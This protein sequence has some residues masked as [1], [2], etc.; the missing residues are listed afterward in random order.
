MALFYSKSVA[1]TVELGKKLGSKLKRGNVVAYFGPMG[2][3][4]TAFTHGLAAGLGIDEKC[5]SSPTFAL[6]HEYRGE[7]AVLY[8]FDMYRISTWDDLYSTGYFDYL[9]S[10]E[11]LAVE[12]S[13]NIENALPDDCIRVNFSSGSNENE[14]NIEIIGVDLD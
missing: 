4:K 6:V 8:H 7:N 2:M 1:D 11:I 12:W 3:G 10:S 13:E 9:D 5:V 14:R